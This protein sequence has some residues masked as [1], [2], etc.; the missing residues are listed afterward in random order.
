MYTEIYTPIFFLKCWIC[1]LL[2]DEC[3]LLRNIIKGCSFIVFRSGGL[4]RSKS[5]VQQV[6]RLVIFLSTSEISVRILMREALLPTLWAPL[7]PA[8]TPWPQGLPI[9]IAFG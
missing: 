5:G 4:W 2:G 1:F 8:G 9:Y 6:T 3:N 7:G